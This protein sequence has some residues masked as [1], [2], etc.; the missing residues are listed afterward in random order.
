[1]GLQYASGGCMQRKKSDS[2]KHKKMYVR[3][4]VIRRNRKFCVPLRINGETCS[5]STVNP[6]PPDLR[7]RESALN[8]P[9]FQ[10]TDKGTSASYFLF[11]CFFASLFLARQ[12]PLGQGLLI[13]EVSGSHSD[14]PQSVGFLCMCDQLLVQTST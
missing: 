3:Y 12:P 6:P 1:M 13:H 10:P 7:S 14:K 9:P 8:N 4:L 5:E 11:V 2:P